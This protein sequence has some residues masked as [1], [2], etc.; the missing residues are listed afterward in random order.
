LFQKLIFDFFEIATNVSIMLLNTIN[1]QIIVFSDGPKIEEI[2][3]DLPIKVD[4]YTFNPSLFRKNNAKN[5]LAYSKEILKKCVNKPV[6]LEVISDT[7]QE[8]VEQALKLGA[9]KNNVYVKIPIVFTN[10]DSTKRVIKSLIE[11]KINLN[12]TAIFTLDQ[13]KNIISEIKDTKTI[14]SVFIGRVFDSGVDGQKH[15]TEIN[16]FIHNNSNCQSL[17]ASTRMPYDIIK[18]INSKTDIITMQVDQIKKLNNFN[19]NLNEYSKETVAQ[20][21]KDAHESGYYF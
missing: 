19:K 10:G 6:S 12:I 3:I 20:F 15:M 4:G 5:Y 17:W 1:K 14:L 13:I 11:Q 21:Y 9:L 8:M 2:E 16:K 7:P 18:A